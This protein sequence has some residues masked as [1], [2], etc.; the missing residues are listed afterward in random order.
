MGVD[1]DSYGQK[2]E[3]V[4]LEEENVFETHQ[5]SMI[6]NE[7]ESQFV[8]PQHFTEYE[9]DNA[10]GEEEAEVYCIC[11]KGAEGFMIGCENCNEWYHGRCVGI[12]ADMGSRLE[13]Y[14][15][16]TCN[17]GSCPAKRR[18]YI[19]YISSASRDFVWPLD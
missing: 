10:I 19:F 17:N 1:L 5:A 2:P 11:K 7:D 12:D 8:N 14:I 4:S 15:C 13:Q 3:F 16:H 6:L 9:D 18:F